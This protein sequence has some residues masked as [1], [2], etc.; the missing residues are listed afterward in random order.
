[1]TA[2]LNKFKVIPD[3]VCVCMCVKLSIFSASYVG[4]RENLTFKEFRTAQ[5]QKAR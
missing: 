1:M 4:Y 3:G 5:T 2:F